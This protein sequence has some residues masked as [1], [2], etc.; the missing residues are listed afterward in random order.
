ML[1]SLD[2]LA[3]FFLKAVKVIFLFFCNFLL[4]ILWRRGHALYQKNGDLQSKN[5]KKTEKKKNKLM[6]CIIDS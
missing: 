5:C 3:P 1:Q 4:K 2:I 6:V